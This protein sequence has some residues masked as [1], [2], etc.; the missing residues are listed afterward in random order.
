M[1][2]PLVGPAAHFPFL[3]FGLCLLHLLRSKGWIGFEPL[4]DLAGPAQVSAVDGLSFSEFQPEIK[5]VG[6][7]FQFFLQPLNRCAQATIGNQLVNRNSGGRSRGGRT[8]TR[9][10]RKR[11]RLDRVVPV[12]GAGAGRTPFRD[13]TSR[14]FDKRR[15]YVPL[16]RDA[17]KLRLRQVTPLP[18]LR[19]EA[20]QHKR[21]RLV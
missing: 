5:I 13:G 3:E 4:N 2:G 21:R 16:V 18:I 11:Q 8:L 17:A 15:W 12:L 14:I 10:V 1:V 9:W 19:I 20:H 7:L 6:P